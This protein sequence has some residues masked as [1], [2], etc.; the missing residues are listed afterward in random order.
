MDRIADATGEEEPLQPGWVAL[1]AALADLLSRPN[2][3]PVGKTSFQKLAYFLTAAAVPT[4]LAFARAT[5]G[6]YAPDLADVT[7]SLTQANLLEESPL[8]S[9][10]TQLT[11]ADAFPAAYATHEHHLAEYQDSIHRSADLL[12]RLRTREAEVAATVHLVATEL[13]SSTGAPPTDSSILTEVLKWQPRKNPPLDETEI[14]NTIHA[15]A[16]LGWLEVDVGVV[17]GV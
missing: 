16:E 9:R 12:A 2:P 14:L 15:L 6:P 1:V 10:M 5:Y 8:G 7:R 4:G 11:P 3:W 17:V 13:S